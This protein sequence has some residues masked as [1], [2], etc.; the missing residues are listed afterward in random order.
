MWLAATVLNSAGLNIPSKNR[1]C[2]TGLKSK[3]QIYVVDKNLNLN[4][5]THIG[6]EQKMEKDKSYKH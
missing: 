5:K 6:E 4:I 3:T 2:Q 1:H